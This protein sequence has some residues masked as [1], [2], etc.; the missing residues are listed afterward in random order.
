MAINKDKLKRMTTLYHS[1]KMLKNNFRKSITSR[2]PRVE[3][4]KNLTEEDNVKTSITSSVS[5]GSSFIS[6]SKGISVIF[7]EESR[8][9]SVANE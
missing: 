6:S 9:P 3:D 5:K 1:S 2:A 8:S 7:E 4:E